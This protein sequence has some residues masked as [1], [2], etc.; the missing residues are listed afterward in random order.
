MRLAS[1]TIQTRR[2]LSRVLFDWTLPP[3]R[4]Q[5]AALYETIRQ[6][7]RTHGRSLVPLKR[8]KD[9]TNAQLRKEL[10]MQS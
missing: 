4:G 10:G 8:I 2:W 6:T 3:P 9:A 1:L 7:R 5:R